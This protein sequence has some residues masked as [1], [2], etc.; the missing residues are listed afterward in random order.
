MQKTIFV[1][2]DSDTILTLA[3]EALE[4][5]FRVMTLPS[6]SGMFALLEKIMPDLIL[7]DVEMPQTNGFEAM[8][9]LKASGEYKNIPVI[10]ATGMS[11]P[12]D[13]AKGRELGA[14][15]FI[16]KPFSG[17]VLLSKIKSHLNIDE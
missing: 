8:K 16:M 1:V 17:S 6:V 13:E 4:N 2:D 7:L 10:F 5:D 3:E 9:R 14:V 11:D 15:D 12:A